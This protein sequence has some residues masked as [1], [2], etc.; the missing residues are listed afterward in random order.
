MAAL[1]NNVLEIDGGKIWN[2]F[3]MKGDA[4][5][6]VSSGDTPGDMNDWTSEGIYH[7]FNP[8]HAP[9]ANHVVCLV[10]C[11]DRSSSHTHQI[12]L[13]IGGDFIIGINRAAHGVHGDRYN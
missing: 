3:H 4:I 9:V 10:L 11:I 2:G 13:T 12:C 5:V 1:K 6:S 7:K 8:T